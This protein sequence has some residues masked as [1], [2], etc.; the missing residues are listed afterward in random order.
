M[1]PFLDVPFLPD[2]KYVEFLGGAGQIDSLHFSLPGER[3]LDSHPSAPAEDFSRVDRDL[4]FR[5]VLEAGPRA[6]PLDR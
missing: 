3:H 4:C 2:E 1:T 5:R 6:D